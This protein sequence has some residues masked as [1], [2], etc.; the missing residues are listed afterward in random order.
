MSEWKTES[1]LQDDYSGVITSATFTTDA[2]YNSGQ[3]LVIA[4]EVAVDDPTDPERAERTQLYSCGS[5]WTSTDGGRTARHESGRERA[6]NR[7]SMYGRVIDW[8]SQQPALMDEFS[9]RGKG[10]TDASVWEG[11]RLRFGTVRVEF[12]RN[13]EAQD[14]TL[15]VEYLGTGSAPQSAS[16]AAGQVTVTGAPVSATATSGT[17]T[18]GATNG[19]AANNAVLLARLRKLAKDAASHQE[20]VDRAVE[21]DGITE[22][23]DLLGRVVDEAG[24]YAEARA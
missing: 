21:L 8:A 12:G 7:N 16:P 20:F 13:L 15:P 9:R 6:F 1:G 23:E 17:A 4:F 19:N 2:R 3:T 22:D 18:N 14:K 11:I 24:I 5:G 10:P